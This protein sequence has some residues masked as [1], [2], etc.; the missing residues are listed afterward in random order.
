MTLYIILVQKN[1]LP[2]EIDE[3]HNSIMTILLISTI[4]IS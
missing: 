4:K 2:N 3:S 1:K